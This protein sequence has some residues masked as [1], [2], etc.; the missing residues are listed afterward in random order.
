MLF[1]R[2]V[3]LVFVR[4]EIVDK[5]FVYGVGVAD[6][7]ITIFVTDFVADSAKFV[8]FFAFFV[9]ICINKIIF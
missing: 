7:I 9:Y 3:V 5:I 1:Q 6:G 2:D 4:L 8:Q